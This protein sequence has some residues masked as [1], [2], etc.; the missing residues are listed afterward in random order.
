MKNPVFYRTIEIDGFS[1]FYRKVG[2]RARA[3]ASSTSWIAVIVANVSRSDFCDRRRVV[4]WLLGQHPIERHRQR[5]L[6]FMKSGD[7]RPVGIARVPRLGV[8][9]D[10]RRLERVKATRSSSRISRFK[11]LSLMRWAHA[12]H[13]D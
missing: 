4:G 3:D 11:S 2:I 9:G 6:R 5:T 12:T 13:E 1:I 10:N 8:A 7:A